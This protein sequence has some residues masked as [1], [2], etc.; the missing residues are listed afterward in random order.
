LGQNIRAQRKRSGFSQEELA[1]K[2][3]LHPVYVGNLER[4][5][6]NISIDSLLRIAKAL[7]VSLGDLV[8]GIRS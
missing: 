6:E 1:E 2:A 3:E 4:G 8:T 7:K 5:E